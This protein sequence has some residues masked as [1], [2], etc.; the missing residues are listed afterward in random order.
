MYFSRRESIATPFFSKIMTEKRFY[1]LLKFLHFSNNENYIYGTSQKLYKI[2]PVLNYLKEKFMSVYIPQKH[3]CVDESLIGWKG[4]L[5]WKQYIPSKRKRYGMKLFVLCES[6][7]GYVYNFIFYTGSDTVYG[8]ANY[9]N[10]PISSRVVLEL[11]HAL[12]N[13]GYCLFLDNYYTSVDLADKLARQKTDCIGTM[14]LTRKG[15]PTEIK[16]KK[17]QKGEK[18]AV[19]IKN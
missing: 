2:L 3:V 16:T 17:L 5:G 8:D 11:M 6:K 12:L 1:L 18:V 15:I 4:R 19:F 13:K 10:E 14:R 9:T 7:T